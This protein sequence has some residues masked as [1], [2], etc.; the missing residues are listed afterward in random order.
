MSRRQIAEEEGT[1]VVSAWRTNPEGLTT[2]DE[3]LAVRFLL[4][5]LRNRVPGRAV[6]LRVPPYG[7]IQIVEGTSHTRGT[8]PAVVEI[9]PRAWLELCNGV[10][11][12]DEL[13]KL[14]RINASGE[15]SNLAPLFPLPELG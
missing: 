2:E 9:D 3:A 5:L 15:R 1:R 8:P 6:E 12:W 7:A 13:V 4:Q 14:G 10:R 11:S